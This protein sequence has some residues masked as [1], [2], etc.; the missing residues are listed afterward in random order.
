MRIG[1]N[2]ALLKN[3]NDVVIAPQCSQH[4]AT[5]SSKSGALNKSFGWR[6]VPRLGFFKPEP[7]QAQTPPVGYYLW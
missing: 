6:R 2:A 7:A 1:S 4:P 3:L 5:L